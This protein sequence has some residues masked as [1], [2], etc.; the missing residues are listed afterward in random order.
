MKNGE[1]Q[2]RQLYKIS[3]AELTENEVIIIAE[4]LAGYK[5]PK[6]VEFVDDFR[7]VRGKILKKDIRAKYWEGREK[8]V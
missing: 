5:K 4:R 2:S 6:S 8:K 3:R 7:E 1:R